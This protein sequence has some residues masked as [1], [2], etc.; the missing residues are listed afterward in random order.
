M[1]EVSVT[2]DMGDSS[3]SFLELTDHICLQFI[4]RDSVMWQNYYE[5]RDKLIS[6][7]YRRTNDLKMIRLRPD[8]T[9]KTLKNFK[10]RISQIGGLQL[11]Y[12]NFTGRCYDGFL[13]ANKQFLDDES[14]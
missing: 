12:F 8:A 6:D 11:N 5:A 13:Q 1:N 7:E 10:V 14:E 4:K 3:M 9:K 2:L